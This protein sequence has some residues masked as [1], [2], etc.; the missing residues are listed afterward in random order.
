MSYYRVGYEDAMG[1]PV[2]RRR[3]WILL[4]EE[5][6]KKARNVQG[7]AAGTTRSGGLGKLRG[8]RR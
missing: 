8:R 6:A 1:I 5:E 3:R 4:A 7:G 2:S